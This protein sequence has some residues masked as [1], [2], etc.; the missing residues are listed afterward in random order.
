MNSIEKAW[1][2]F[3]KDC[4]TNGEWVTKDD[5]DQILEII[6]NHTFIPNVCD[7][8]AGGNVEVSPTMYLKLLREGVLNVDGYPMKNIELEI[9]AKQLDDPKHI[10]LEDD[11]SFIYTYPERLLNVC[12]VTRFGEVVSENQV[13]TMVNRLKEYSGTNR[14]VANLYMCAFDKDEQHIPCLN[15]VQALIRDNELSLHILFRSN[16]CWGAFPSNMFFI[17]YLGMKIT[18]EL[19]NEY[20]LLK[21]RG[22]QYNS[23]SLHI[24]KGDY[25]QAMKVVRGE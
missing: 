15:F 11:N 25:D 23:T 7:S 22:I 8:M 9:Y 12:Q 10:Y 5:G 2:T 20:P 13:T 16:D 21:F 6:D 4:I 17:Q 18:N 1:K 24:Y 14:A 19:K 3:L